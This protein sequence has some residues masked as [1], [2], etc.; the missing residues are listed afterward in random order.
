[1]KKLIINFNTGSKITYT[2][3]KNCIDHMKY[4]ERHE[5][6][7]MKSAI[8]QVYPKKDNEPIDLLKGDEI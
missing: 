4:F 6:A 8:L 5:K 1:M 2:I 7:S 3:T